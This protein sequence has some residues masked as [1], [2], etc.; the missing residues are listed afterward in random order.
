MRKNISEL[1]S[2]NNKNNPVSGHGLYCVQEEILSTNVMTL[3][4]RESEI[5]AP[6]FQIM[7]IYDIYIYGGLKPIF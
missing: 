7:K 6:R 3:N 5:H 4:P 1:Q 2:I